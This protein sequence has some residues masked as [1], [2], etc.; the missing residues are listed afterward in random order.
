MAKG[1]ISP[2]GRVLRFVAW[3][4]PLGVTRYSV[5]RN[6]AVVNEEGRRWLALAGFGLWTAGFW[7]FA[8]FL[9]NWLGMVVP[10][11]LAGLFGLLLIWRVIGHLRRL[12][13]QR[14]SLKNQAVSLQR[15]RQMFEMQAQTLDYLRRLP[16]Q[17][18]PGG[19]FTMLGMKR[20][21]DP[22]GEETRRVAREQ[23]DQV[24]GW[25]GDEQAD[26]PLGDRF[27]PLFRRPRFRRRKNG[28]GQ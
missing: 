13:A 11:Q 5:A 16:G 27:E 9:H 23:A 17:A 14:H 4:L 10:L 20:E 8:T 26:V 3:R 6:M 28:N 19:A 7:Y 25:L 21:T 2:S 1:G 12:W 24:R 18:L 22:V 15:Q